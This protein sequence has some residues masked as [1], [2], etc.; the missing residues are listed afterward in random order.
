M[1]DHR[2]L[3]G[4]LKCFPREQEPGEP[5]YGVQAWVWKTLLST[6]SCVGLRGAS[7]L[8]PF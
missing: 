8:L 4:C 7:R 1:P 5:A 2:I 3:I 6:R